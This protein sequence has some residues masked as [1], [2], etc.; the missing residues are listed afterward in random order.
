MP[1]DPFPEQVAGDDVARFFRM[2]L[3]DR[4]APKFVLRF[5]GF[6]LTSLLVS[7]VVYMSLELVVRQCTTS[8]TCRT[9]NSWLGFMNGW[10]FGWRLLLGMS[11]ISLAARRV[12]SA[13]RGRSG[14]RRPPAGLA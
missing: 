12:L 1:A 3:G 13:G 10:D 8:D 5:L 14:T 2:L 7:N 6:V 4:P 9:N 11:A